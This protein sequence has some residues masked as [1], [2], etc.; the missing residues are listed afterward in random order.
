MRVLLTLFMFLFGLLPKE[1]LIVTE[2]ILT[3]SGK[4]TLGGFSCEY[5]DRDFQD[6]LFID[7]KNRST[8]PDLVFDIPVREFACGN[9]V[10]N[11]DFR[12][13]IKAEEY[14]T[15]LIKVREFRA[16]GKHIVCDLQVELAGKKL[17]Y[18]NL[19]LQRKENGLVGNLILSFDE[20]ELKAPH[21]MGGLIKVNE[22][23]ILNFHLGVIN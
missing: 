20:L 3:V 19:V 10:L 23:L 16:K 6:T 11:S 13:T 12:K 22:E 17:E 18:K 1:E 2:K 9:F 4:T 7:T 15:A 14:P 5:V 21:K 8:N